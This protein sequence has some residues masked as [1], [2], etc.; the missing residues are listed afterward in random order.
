M[1][2]VRNT[3]IVLLSSLGCAVPAFTLQAGET[4]EPDQGTVLLAG[5]LLQPD[6]TL[7]DHATVVVRAGQITRVSQEAEG[8]GLPPHQLPPE[9][10]IC[11]GLV[12]LFALPSVVEQTIED[13]KTIDPDASPARGLDPSHR[14]FRAALEAGITAVMV[15]PAA[16]NLVSG[17]CVTTRTH[18][19][20]GQL[21]ILR[22]EGPLVLAV[23]EG[24]WRADRAPTSRS[25]AMHDLRKLLAQARAGAAH[26]RLNAVVRGELDAWIACSTGQDVTATRRAL[27]DLS[28]YFGVVVS[29]DAIDVVGSLQ[30]V[31]PPVVLGPY[32]METSR[33][34]I[35]GAAALTEAGIEVA[36]RAGF[37]VTGRDALRLTAAL[38]VRHGMDPA[39]ARRAIT[40]A[41][42]E[43]AGVADRIGSVAPGK[44]GDLVVFSG[45]PLRMDARVLEVY[46]RGQ[47]VYSA[48]DQK[49][50]LA[51]G[52]P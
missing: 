52:Q 16:T 22:D 36:F 20:H 23:G 34:E 51:G 46:V 48:R 18:V 37:P 12:E 8:E 38:A 28:K 32:S 45:D 39:A 30:D 14:D 15:G 49:A 2:M 29:Q 43:V 10:V 26:P 1:T 7:L 24:V 31:R 25:G 42:A 47:R 4:A 50:T 13:A 17:V 3:L 9:S 35:L 41:P 5:Q 6:G 11:P 21:D 19:A 44:D 40:I 27:G 33:R